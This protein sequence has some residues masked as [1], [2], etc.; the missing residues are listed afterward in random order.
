MAMYE[1]ATPNLLHVTDIIARL[2]APIE[3]GIG[4]TG[5]R[6]LIPI[7]GGEARGPRLSGTILAGGADSQL[8]RHD[9][10]AEVQARYV[11]ETVHGDRVYVENTGMRHAPP[12]LMDRLIKNQPVDPALVYFRSVP[13]FETSAVALSWLSRAIFVCSGAR[14]PDHVQLR[15]FEVT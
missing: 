7:L 1:I 3:V 4:P 10:L 13:R 8:I 9:N 6:R 12:E 5:A 2:S 14:F 11:I 15:I